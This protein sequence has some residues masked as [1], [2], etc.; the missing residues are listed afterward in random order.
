MRVFIAL[1]LPREGINEIER[2]QELI[3]KKNLFMGKFTEGENLHLTLKF[4]GEISDEKII[5]VRKRLKDVKFDSFDAELGE[6]GIFAR[7]FIRIIWI[8]LNDAG[9]LQK[10]IDKKLDGLF[11]PEFRFMSHITLARVKK[12]GDKKGL[13]DYIKNI[14]VKK[15]KFRV[16][17]FFLKKSELKPEGPVYEDLEEYILGSK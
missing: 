10:E 1:D 5:E 9:R 2:I 6:V 4:L 8:K 13:I 7:K 17:D 15:I 3:K 12:V 11:E 16:K 14:K